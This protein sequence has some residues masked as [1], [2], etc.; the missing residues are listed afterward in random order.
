[1]FSTA[2]LKD[3][4]GASP[5]YT[6]TG[7]TSYAAPQVSGAAALVRAQFPCL[8]ALETADMLVTSA[9]DIESIGTNGNYA[10]KIGKRLDMAAALTPVADPCEPI[11]VQETD[12]RPLFLVYPN[13]SAN[14]ITVRTTA[15][16][17]WNL[18]V[19]DAQGKRVLEQQF[20][21]RDQTISGLA[22][23]LYTVSLANGSERSVQ[24]VVVAH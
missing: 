5:I 3:T 18:V 19:T 24:R 17:N 16:G 15:S 21:G 1:V 22:P 14:E 7:G 11:G 9:V 10:G 6:T 12:M 8:T 13:P 20:I 2:T 23:G 4:P